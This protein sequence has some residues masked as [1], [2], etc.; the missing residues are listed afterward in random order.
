MSSN[1]IWFNQIPNGVN[2][3]I[4]QIIGVIAITT[5]DLVFFLLTFH[6]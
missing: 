4:I 1:I 5:Q 2:I 3:D 6:V